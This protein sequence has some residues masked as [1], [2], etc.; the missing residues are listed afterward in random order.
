M[1]QT[2]RTGIRRALA[3]LLIRAAARIWPLR[4]MSD[5]RVYEALRGLAR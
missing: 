3:V 2:P 1:T 4:H 5:V